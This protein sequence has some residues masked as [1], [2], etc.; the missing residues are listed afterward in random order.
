M[1]T[2]KATTALCST[3]PVNLSREFDPNASPFFELPVEAASAYRNAVLLDTVAAPRRCR[4]PMFRIN[5]R[6]ASSSHNDQSC[7]FTF[8]PAFHVLVTSSASSAF[9]LL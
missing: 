9:R 4:H 8:P 3:G 7:E 6:S 1:E 5:D 2:K